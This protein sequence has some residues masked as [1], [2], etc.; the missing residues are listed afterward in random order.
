MNVAIIGLGVISSTH[1]DAINSYGAN[2]VAVC[3][4]QEEKMQKFDCAK[5][6]DYHELLKRDDI[7]IVHICTPHFLHPQMVI[8]CA[9][10]GKN[11]LVEKPAA[12]KTEQLMEM[13]E[14]KNGKKISVCFQNR[15]NNGTKIAKDIINKKIYGDIL[16]VYAL[17]PWYRNNDYYEKSDWRGKLATEGG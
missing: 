14:N 4:I 17:V 6:I 9:N 11:V 2:L 7:D 16:G 8:D 1:I 3:D 10:A 5:Y 15:Y 13:I 12:T